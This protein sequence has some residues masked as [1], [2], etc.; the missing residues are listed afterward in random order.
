MN[1]ANMGRR[2]EIAFWI[3]AVAFLMHLKEKKVFFYVSSFALIASC[4]SII[5][6]V[7]VSASSPAAVDLPA[8]QAPLS[9]SPDYSIKPLAEGQHNT[10][11]ILVDEMGQPDPKLEGMWLVVRHIPSPQVMLLPLYP[12]P[13][14]QDDD[15]L[16]EFFRLNADGAPAH[17]FL[18]GL[19]SKDLRWDSL[20]VLDK[21]SLAQMI[22]LVGGV[23]LGQGVLSGDQAMAHLPSSRHLPESALSVQAGLVLELCKRTPRLALSGDPISELE[24]FSEHVYLDPRFKQ[25]AA[26]W[27]QLQDEIRTVSCEMPTLHRVPNPMD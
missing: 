1:L 16:V 6:W 18:Q 3:G 7:V 5:A 13:E 20:L 8:E 14:N 4:L 22:Q 9:A 10:L 23:D 2:L 27:V 21:A 11:V 12:R 15:I 19:Q 26:S 24:Q 25:V 17:V